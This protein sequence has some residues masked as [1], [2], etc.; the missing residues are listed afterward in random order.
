VEAQHIHHP[1]R[2]ERCS[3]QIG[4]LRH[5]GANQQATIAATLDCQSRAFGVL[6]FDQPLGSGNKIIEDIL[7]F[8]FGSCPV[9]LLSILPPTAQICHR[10]DASH[11]HPCQP[12]DRKLRGQRNV[13]AA[14]SIQQNWILAIFLQA[15]LMGQEHGKTRAIFAI[16]KNLF[17]NIFAR[18]EWDLAAP[19]LLTV[20]RRQ[21]ES[22]DAGGDGKTGKGIEGFQIGPLAAKSRCRTDP[23]QLKLRDERTL[24]R[25]N[26]NLRLRVLQ[27]AGQKHISHQ[28]DRAH[29]IFGLG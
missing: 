21:V 8:E 25:I 29:D 24:Q 12:A 22:V 16:Q 23:R 10:Q 14:V 28:A 20:T 6:L 9:P 27:V 13:E 4:P 19:K 26:D 18:I 7:L 11:F 17:G 1:N 15:L 2:R 5:A 3:E